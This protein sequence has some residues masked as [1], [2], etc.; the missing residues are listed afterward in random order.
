MSDYDGE[1]CPMTVHDVHIHRKTGSDKEG[2]EILSCFDSLINTLNDEMVIFKDL[3]VSLRSER[4]L[5]V[6][7][8]MD[9]LKANNESRER[10]LEKAGL[11]NDVRTSIV[12]K[13][14]AYFELDGD[15]IS[16]SHLISCADDKHRNQLTECRSTLRSLLHEIIES[17]NQN[18][19]LINSSAQYTSKSLEFLRDMMAPT[20]TYGETGQLK[21]DKSNGSIIRRVG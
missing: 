6:K 13:I 7:L 1:V 8:S 19:M 15:H 5:L 21:K 10:I 11:L 20:S 2:M 12:S 18:M 3:S 9:E 14:A 16:L 17:N 4:E